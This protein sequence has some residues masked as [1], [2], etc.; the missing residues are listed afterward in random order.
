M[1]ILLRI[2]TASSVLLFCLLALT[3]STSA[4]AAVGRAG[5]R[6]DEYTKRIYLVA[7]E[8]ISRIANGEKSNATFVI[9]DD[10]LADWGL[11]TEWTKDELGADAI[12]DAAQ[13]QAAFYAQ[14]PDANRLMDALLHDCPYEL[15]WYDKTEGYRKSCQ[16]TQSGY[17]TD[18]RPG[19]DVIESVHITEL[20]FSLYVSA[21]YQAGGYSPQSINVDTVKTA[22][23]ATVLA[24][25]DAIVSRY[26]SLS[27]YDKLVAYRNE[28]C[29]LVTYDS[30]AASD[31]Y[32]GRYGNPWQLISV[33]DDDVTT[34]VVCEGYAKA[35][36][37][38]CDRSDFIDRV[39]CYTVSGDMHGGTGAGG[40]MWNILSMGD[41]CYYLVDVTNSDE[42]SV[43]Q[44][45][46]LFLSGYTRFLTNG[47][48]FS[49]GGTEIT[50]TYD[51]TTRALWGV[52]ETSV[53]RLSRNDY[54]PPAIIIA[55][56]QND[57]LYSGNALTV[58]TKDGN[59]IVCRGDMFE[60]ADFH[61]SFT[62]YK[63]NDRMSEAPK[64]AGSYRLVVRAVNRADAGEAYQTEKTVVIAKATPNYTVPTDL[65]A[66]FGTLLSDVVLPNGF[67]WQSPSQKVGDVGTRE[68]LAAYTPADT[69]N[70]HAVT[71]VRIKINV[72]PLDI[73][74]AVIELDGDLSYNG[75][76]QI[77]TVK[78]VTLD[79]IDIRTYEIVGN[80]A[81]EAGTYILT[82]TG[83]GNYC[84]SAS[85]AWTIAPAAPEQDTAST[86][87]LEKTMEP[88]SEV[89]PIDQVRSNDQMLQ[90][91][92]I[93]LSA[94]GIVVILTVIIVAV[95]KKK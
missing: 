87:E 51:D 76:L 56:P 2:L 3:F 35:F 26:A 66:I 44:D 86:S 65:T 75:K 52:E 21:D 29:N 9:S 80:S 20:Q 32:T 5:E 83:T 63:G 91:I 28:I 13:V 33:F 14:L 24:R 27:D 58:G 1:K 31:S 92:V 8:E 6:L 49:V 43:G 38:L 59:V 10:T 23:A 73:T 88:T 42:G 93:G 15:Y 34:N 89:Q 37:Y 30:I 95:S 85:V 4:S 19:I 82:V 40:H 25:A 36:Q 69:Q 74:N 84:G 48:C 46:G 71:D 45:G 72:L 61:W 55:M 18:S 47:Y 7:K 67:A 17:D 22:Y 53:L 68:F 39:A 12:E 16:I 57:I 77:P 94:V 50:F 54:R 81:T 90:L 70:Y 11:K 79:G 41:G 60:S 64:N 78:S 62:W